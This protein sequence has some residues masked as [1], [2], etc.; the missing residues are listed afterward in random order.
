M[1]QALSACLFL[2]LLVAC[3]PAGAP[4]PTANPAATSAAAPPKPAVGPSGQPKAGGTLRVALWQEPDSLNYYFSTQ[5]V[6]RITA[7]MV[8]DGLTRGGPDGTYQPALAAEIPTQQNGGVS[9]DG[10][11]VT[12][13]LKQGV[14][15]SDG[16]PLTSDD[17]LFTY[18]VIMDPANPVTS[19]ATYVII[20]TITAPDPSTIV[21]TYK[22]IFAAYRAAF[23]VVLPAHVFNGQSSIDKHPFNRAPIGTGP[24]LFKSWAS[25]DTIT[26]ERN[27]RYRE[28]GKP[29]LDQVIYKITPSREA[30]IQAFKVGDIDV[31]WNLIEANI[32]EFEAMSDAAIDPTPSPSIERLHFNLSCSSGRQQGDPTCPHPILNDARVRQAIE[33]GIDKQGLVDQLL[34]GKAKVATSSLAGYFNPNLPP[35]EFNPDKARQ[36]LDAAGWQAGADGVRTRNGVRAHI[37]IS[38]TTGDALREQAEQLIQEELKAVG[39]ELEVRNVTSPVL[40]GTWA[41]NGLAARGGSDIGMWATSFAIDPQAG[42]TNYMSDQVPSDGTPSGQNWWRLQDAELDNMIVKAG[43]ILDDPA[44]KAAYKDIAVRLDADKVVI[45][46]YSRLTIDARKTFVQGW[47]TNVWDNLSWHSQDWWLSK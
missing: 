46:L 36:V 1:L 30:S 8:M 13:K 32:P 10:R 6:N 47:Q 12:W 27:P 43:T 35:S 38:S 15:W 11:A 2:V 40:L 29:L 18:R 4:G 9:S 33:L 22:D 5:T 3:V 31:L 42:L 7:F 25:G 45:P 44:R 14:T 21:V 26:F 20:D 17:V 19:R 24:Y 28:A 16:Q 37:A 39:I 23:P 34:L 41:S